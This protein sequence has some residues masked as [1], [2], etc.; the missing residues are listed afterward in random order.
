MSA[1]RPADPMRRAV[2]QGELTMQNFLSRSGANEILRPADPLP[3]GTVWQQN[4]AFAF[5]YYDNI[6]TVKRFSAIRNSLGYHDK[7]SEI[8]VAD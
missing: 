3:F 2:F 7:S 1:Y 8:S 4:N 6:Y 5:K